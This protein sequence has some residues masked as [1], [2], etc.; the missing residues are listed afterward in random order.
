MARA[1]NS[2]LDGLATYA[3]QIEEPLLVCGDF[4]L[5]PYSPFFDRFAEAAGLSD[6]RRARGL[7]LSWPSFMPLLG[8][9]IDHC[10]IRGP[11]E[12]ESVERLNRIGSDHYPV[13]VTLVWQDNE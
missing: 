1:R 9:P 11:I 5:T 10:L 8:I 13:Q 4:N 2:Q 12:V 7:G 6:V 3:S